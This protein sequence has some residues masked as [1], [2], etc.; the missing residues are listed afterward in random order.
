MFVDRFPDMNYA[1][2]RLVFA[3]RLK[4]GMQVRLIADDLG[5]TYSWAVIS[6][7]RMGVSETGTVHFFGTH[8]DGTQS[9]VQSNVNHGWLVKID[10]IPKEE[11]PS[12]EMAVSLDVLEDVPFEQAR[13]IVNSWA[14]ERGMRLIVPTKGSLLDPSEI[15]DNFVNSNLEFFR[16]NEYILLTKI[17]SRLLDYLTVN[18]IGWRPDLAEVGKLSKKYYRSTSY[19]EAERPGGTPTKL[20]EFLK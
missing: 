1:T 17:N 4:N 7:F 13:S 18:R 20:I 11:D 5:E 2:E 8:E 14:K 6:D 12:R 3:D 19:D 16:A 9:S 10:S 15:F